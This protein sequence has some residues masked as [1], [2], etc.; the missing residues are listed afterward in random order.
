MAIQVVTVQAV[1]GEM[2]GVSCNLLHV[3]REVA[4]GIAK[5]VITEMAVRFRCDVLDTLASDR[6]SAYDW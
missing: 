3:R 1:L 2:L 4:D 5:I 6:E